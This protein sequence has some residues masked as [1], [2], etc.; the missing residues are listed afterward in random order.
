MPRY[1]KEYANSLLRQ[2]KRYK[3]IDKYNQVI[4]VLNSRERGMITDN[5]TM[6]CFIEIWKAGTE[7]DHN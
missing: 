3:M 2:F 5:E 4:N 7:Y 1:I 6:Y